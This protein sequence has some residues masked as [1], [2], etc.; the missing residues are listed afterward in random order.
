MSRRILVVLV[1][2]AIL[3]AILSVAGLLLASCTERDT[4][5][6][7]TSAALGVASTQ[8]TDAVQHPGDAAVSSEGS[9]GPMTT[10]IALGIA[11]TQG[12]RVVQQFGDT[13]VSYLNGE[14]DLAAVQALVASSAQDGLA[15]ML[16]SLGRPTG[17]EV[18]GM[19][20]YDLSV[21]IDVDLLFVGGTS[22]PADYTVTILVDQDKGTATIVAIEPGDRYAPTNTTAVTTI[23]AAADGGANDSSL[24][25]IQ[26]QDDP[27]LWYMTPHYS[28][29]AADAV[30]LAKVVEVLPLRRNPLAGPQ[31]SERSDEHQP[32]VYKG[33]VLEVEKAYG[34]DSVPRRITIYTLGNGTIELDGVAYE[35]RTEYPLDADPGDRFFLPLMKV[36]Y[37]GTPE[38]GQ[39][40]YWVQA[41]WALFA[42]DDSDNC[43][44]V[45]GAD[46]DP[47]NGSEFP[48]SELE[49]IAVEKGK[50][51]SLIQ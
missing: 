36:A 35:V 37:F 6:M 13:A 24:P 2:C 41:N 16:S 26:V 50:K 12:T 3:S 29:I 48:L 39:D 17:C 21:E 40:E 31:D 14:G 20:Q 49:G 18:M 7:T 1:S 46:V 19:A 44:R 30:A 22:G 32:V 38:L 43:T 42:V 4:E 23:V 27:N 45:T 15:R 11:C 51:P 47:E 28:F 5:S 10:S 8:G 25:V 34:P 9:D 33:Y